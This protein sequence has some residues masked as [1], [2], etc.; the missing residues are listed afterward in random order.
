MAKKRKRKTINYWGLM[1]IPITIIIACLIIG[2]AVKEKKAA[3]YNSSIPSIITNR[4]ANNED[5]VVDGNKI[6]SLSPKIVLIP[7]Y[8][9]NDLIIEI[10]YYNKNHTLIYS[11]QKNIG[12]VKAGVEYD[13]DFELGDIP[14]F[15]LGQIED[16]SFEVVHGLV[17]RFQRELIIE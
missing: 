4:L 3:P 5:F 11:T 12:D 9:I 13:I 8:N 14:I 7:K 10:C 6:L 17:F 15:Q 1:S 16:G 2:F